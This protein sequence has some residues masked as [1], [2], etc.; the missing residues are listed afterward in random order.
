MSQET[1]RDRIQHICDLIRHETL[2]PA[3]R[4]KQRCIAEGELRRQELIQEGLQEKERLLSEGRTALAKERYAFENALKQ[5]TQ[6][7]LETFKQ[8]VENKLFQPEIMRFVDTA[9]TVPET[10]SKFIN[11]LITAI[12]NAG[13]GVD[14]QVAVGQ[15]VDATTVSKLLTKEMLER[16]QC[17]PTQSHAFNG[18]VEVAVTDA[19]ITVRMSDIELKKLLADHLHKE[20]RS[21]VFAV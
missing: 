6:Q 20:F 10:A 7:A 1:G 12:E 3:E 17:E 18:G 13:L 15:N 14:L 8:Q 2:E 11:T 9:I 19:N 21:L 5:A 4:E 16:L